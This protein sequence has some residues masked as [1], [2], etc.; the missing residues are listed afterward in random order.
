MP[1][2]LNQLLDIDFLQRTFPRFPL[3]PSAA[4]YAD[5]KDPVQVEALS[6]ACMMLRRDVFERAGG[7]SPEY[8]MF[9]ED[10]DL[11]W[12]VQSADLV[13]LYVPDAVIVH[14]G[15]GSTRKSRSRLADIMIPESVTR[16]LAKTRGRLYSSLYRGALGASAVLRLVLLAASSPAGLLSGRSE[17]WHAVAGK[18]WAVLRWSLGLEQWAKRYGQSR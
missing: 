11:C 5:T 4:A 1:S 16:L 13:N 10:L 14:H 2:I 3:W 17:T 18:W 15:G 7:F 9:G 12:K 8:F 6:G